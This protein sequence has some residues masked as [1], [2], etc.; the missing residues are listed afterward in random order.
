MRAPRFLDRLLPLLAIAAA[1]SLGCPQPSP[2]PAP[3]VPDGSV[4]LPDSGSE[5]N[6]DGGAPDGGAPD[7][8]AGARDDAGT[9]DAGTDA[10]RGEPVSPPVV[11]LRADG[12]R[13]GE[14]S[15]DG[16]AD[17]EGEA[18]W[19]ADAGA[20]FLANIDDDEKRCPTTGTDI[21]LPK[22]NDA[23][24]ERI[25]GD[26]DLLDLAPLKVLAWPAAP[27]GAVGRLEISPAAAAA[28]VRLFKQ[29][30]G[31]DGGVDGGAASLWRPF[32]P[33]KDSLPAE[34]LRAG[35]DL[36]LEGKD[37]V[38]DRAAWDGY[39][40]VTL[41]LSTPGA[42]GGAGEGAWDGGARY[43]GFAASDS[44]VLRVSPVMTFS[45]ETAAQTLYATALSGADSTLFRAD[46]QA[47]LNLAQNTQ[48]LVGLVTERG[49]QWAQ[50]YFETGYMAMP[51]KGGRQV[52]RVNLRSANVD[53][54]SPSS[55]LRNAGRLVF[56]FLRGPDV[57]GI[58]EY[59]PQA[60][61]NAQD[62]LN[63]F[64]NFETIPP[65]T[66]GGVSYPLGRVLRG[67]IPSRHIDPNFQ[68]MT[69]AQA[70]QPPIYIDTAWLS[71]GHVDETISFLPVA[72]P[73]GWIL[74]ISD[75]ALAKTMLEAAVTAGN[76]AVLMFDGRKTRTGASAAR[77]ISSVLASTT[78]MN[79]SAKAAAAVDAQLAILKA[80]TGVTDAEII[81]VPFLYEPTGA[82]SLAYQP[83]TVNGVM[84]SPTVF[85]PPDPHGPVI[86]GKDLFK[87]HL[88]AALAVHNIQ[89]HWVEDWNLYH[90]LSGEVHCGSN[91]ARV[92]PAT[93]WWETGR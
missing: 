64:G 93:N 6:E 69:E 10:G 82:G 38:R 86:N 55:P 85:A 87:A 2:P 18:Q 11:D 47:G 36:L 7:P 42:D 48:P 53:F 77:S 78:I 72:S 91:A 1:M 15:T 20:V 52:I 34:A 5:P 14:V 17:E 44:V 3:P 30:P 51:A 50:D 75:P 54:N 89:L 25:N 28:K 39:A 83:G 81:R 12:D 67:S 80:E 76:G 45:H 79:E 92:L 60:V 61:N 71:V 84:I 29:D 22:C 73:R 4:T 88:E 35:V 56:T 33:T 74:L 59:L 63:S 58:Q 62:S 46:L 37:I 49:D 31:A 23:A 26:R 70:M 57:A 27:E 19:S 13:N 41:T 16:G 66:H 43:E 65:Y 90:L 24:D 9:P 8:D 68:K 21:E 40:T 32:E